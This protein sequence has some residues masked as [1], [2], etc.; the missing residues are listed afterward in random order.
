[1]NPAK[2]IIISNVPPFF[3][4]EVLAKELQRHGQLV[5]PIKLI[6]MSCKSPHLKH[7]MSFRRQVLMVLK[8]NDEELNL[9]FKYKID[10]YELE[11]C[12]PTRTRGSRNTV[13]FRVGFRVN[14]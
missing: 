3:K 8:N 5:S 6:P 13:G 11:V 12:Y 2:K 4:N 9:V 1:M 14:V 10:G 7:V